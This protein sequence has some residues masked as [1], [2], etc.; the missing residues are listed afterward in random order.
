MATKAS[1]PLLGQASP[2]RKMTFRWVSQEAAVERWR[3]QQRL[4]GALEDKLVFSS[5][6]RGGL[7]GAA[8]ELDD[9]P[10]GYDV[11]GTREAGFDGAKMLL[12]I[13]LA[14]PSS[15]PALGLL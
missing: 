5:I 2:G 4:L 13:D 1:L 6:N 8:F 3:E 11:A 10:T 14:D 15:W 9:R 7:Q 12:R